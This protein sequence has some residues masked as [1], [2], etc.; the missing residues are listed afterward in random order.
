MEDIETTEKAEQKRKLVVVPKEAGRN[1]IVDR[2]NRAIETKAIS[3]YVW[4]TP[5]LPMLIFVTIGL[6]TA[7]I[8]GDIVW[9]LISLFL[10]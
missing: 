8:F 1:E 5:G 9:I 4:S 3:D 2:L 7:I 6:I 10:N